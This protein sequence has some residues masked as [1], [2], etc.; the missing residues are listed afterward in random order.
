[1]CVFLCEFKRFL[2]VCLCVFE[3]LVRVCYLP[4]TGYCIPDIMGA[5]VCMCVFI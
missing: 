3:R 5:C 4:L 1:M 2:C